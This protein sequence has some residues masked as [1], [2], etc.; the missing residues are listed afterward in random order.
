MSASSRP[1][2][3]Y[4]E[5]SESSAAHYLVA[6]L[7]E[8]DRKL[9]IPVALESPCELTP[10]LLLAILESLTRQ[11][12]PIPPAVRAARD[13]EAKVQAMKI[14]LGVLE[15]DVLG[16]DVG[17]S[18]VDPRRLAAGEWD[19]VVFVGEVLCWL[20][21]VFGFI[22][23]AQ[24]MHPRHKMYV[25][26]DEESEDDGAGDATQTNKRA[27]S[28]S[29]HRPPR[30]QDYS[31]TTSSSAN[32]SLSIS[33]AGPAHATDTTVL[34]AEPDSDTEAPSL[35]ELSLFD[36]PSRIGRYSTSTPPP[37][38]PPRPRSL[39]ARTPRCIHEVEEPSVADHEHYDA[40]DAGYTDD[41]TR[42]DADP[43]DAST[44]SYCECLPDPESPLARYAQPKPQAAPVRRAGWLREADLEDE[45]RTFGGTKASTRT[46]VR[47]SV[48]PPTFAF[49]SR[50]PPS[51]ASPAV[52]KTPVGARPAARI[53]TRHTSPSE[54]TL[55]L[56]SERAKLLEELATLKA[57]GRS[58]TPSRT[59]R[60]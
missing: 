34:S 33:H 43:V 10:S 27:S 55:A 45:L 11:R 16:E 18:A 60:P 5:P 51:R 30:G 13:R 15:T 19:E 58:D 53:V 40:S 46:R 44:A 24:V 29:G 21:K 7:N 9:G 2:P 39:S 17:L 37:S 20:G 32:S 8:L 59:R 3:S 4:A 42:S 56:L 23:H 49:A 52:A 48:S 14:F 57:A 50:G 25:G 1:T 28:S 31:P 47:D 22:P 54:Y 6:Y 26:G 41:E 38:P 36:A 12:L 35:S